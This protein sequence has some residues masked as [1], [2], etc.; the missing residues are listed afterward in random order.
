MIV[1]HNGRYSLR[2][3]HVTILVG[4]L[5]PLLPL[6]IWSFAH[7]WF[8]PDLL[9]AEWS[10]RAWRYVFSSGSRVGTALFYSSVTAL[11][12]TF[13][14]LLIGIPAGRAL[15]LYDFR[16]K[17]AVT[18]LILAPAIMPVIA[19]AMGIHVAFIRLGLADSLPGLILSHLIPVTPYVVLIMASVFA[20]YNPDYERQA[21]TLGARPYQVLRYVMLPA[22]KPGL[23]VAG[24]FA[25]IISWGQY[26]LNLLIGGGRILTM[27]VLLFT[28]ASSGDN[29]MTAAL[30]IVFI[31]PALL[32]LLVTVGYVTGRE[33]LLGGMSSS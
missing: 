8:F 11:A 24:M 18:F 23:I 32:L 33:D 25:F 27:P 29:A 20:N 6:I 5:V 13:M 17:T 2:L 10:W 22:I 31:A 26:L 9:P 16:G 21:R 7:R 4:I 14:S 30:S 15:A 19:V 3:T 1:E 28:F 12:V